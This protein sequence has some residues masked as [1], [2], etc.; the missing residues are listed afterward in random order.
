MPSP[1]WFMNLPIEFL[2]LRMCIRNR[3]D[4]TLALF[5][6]NRQ[7]IQEELGKEMKT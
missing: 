1:P 6:T 7:I 3:N 5:V 4:N 2:P